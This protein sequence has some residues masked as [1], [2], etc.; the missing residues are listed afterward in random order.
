V[1]SHVNDMWN[2]RD[3]SQQKR[4]RTR[5]LSRVKV[6]NIFIMKKLF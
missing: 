4:L 2:G 3:H 6:K 1:N 5:V